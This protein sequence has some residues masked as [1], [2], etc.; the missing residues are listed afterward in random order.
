MARI[1]RLKR[2]TLSISGKLIERLPVVTNGLVAHFPFDGKGGMVDV[3]NGVTPVQAAAS[4]VNI[5]DCLMNSWR[6]PASWNVACVWDEAEQAIKFSIPSTI[7]VLSTYIPVDTSKHW[8]VEAAIK[9]A[10]GANGILYLG[11]ISY[12]ANKTQLP[13][14]P[15]TYDY[16]AAQGDTTVT[17][18][19]YTTFNNKLIG[20][21]NGTGKT[22]EDANTGNYTAFHPGTKF[23]RIMILTNYT[24]TVG[25]CFVK[26]L[27]LYHKD[28][29]TSNIVVHGS[30]ISLNEPV[31]NVSVMDGQNG[32]SPW[33]GDGSPSISIVDP[34]IEFRG[35]R[36]VRF[37]TGTAGNCY[38]TGST[39]IGTSISSVEW[40]NSLYIRRLDGSSIT[41]TGGYLYITNNTNVNGSVIIEE[42]EDKWYRIRYTRVGLVSGYPTLAG[43]Y[44]LGASTEYLFADWQIEPKPYASGYKAGAK[45]SSNL[46]LNVSA[47]GP[48]TL[49][50]DFI[51]ISPNNYA[52]Y[53]NWIFTHSPYN[54][55][56]IMW[57]RTAEDYYR[58]R[59]NAVDFTFLNTD[60]TNNNRY[61]VTLVMDTVK[62][63][64]FL[65]GVYKGEI[66]QVVDIT[67]LR[68]GSDEA[69]P[70]GNSKFYG[71]TIYNRALSSDEVMKLYH[72]SFQLK[73]NGNL[74]TRK[75]VEKPLSIPA[76]VVHFPLTCDLKDSYKNNNTVMWKSLV[77]V[78]VTD[79]TIKKTSATPA[80]DAGCVATE[81]VYGD[82]ILSF[83]CGQL[84]QDKMIG[85]SNIA[86]S[87]AVYSD[88]DHAIY[89]MANNKIQIYE[90][91]G[92]RGD[93]GSYA[94]NDIFTVNCENSVVKYYQ[95]GI[96]LYTSALAPT[97]PLTI[98][99]S[100]HTVGGLISDI[101][102]Y[103]R[104]PSC[105]FKEG[106][107]WVGKATTNL[108]RHANSPTDFNVIGNGIV[109]PTKFSDDHYEYEYR[110][111]QNLTWTYH[112]QSF[113]IVVGQVYMVSVD[114]FIS[115][116]T[117][118]PSTG[119]QFVA[120]CEGGLGISFYYDNTKK[121]QWQRLRSYAT[122]S[123]TASNFLMYP[124]TDG[125]PA[126]TG[127]V[128]Y[129]NIQV[130]RKNNYHTP[131]VNGIRAI[132]KPTFP[133]SLISL[134]EGTIA[135]WFK[136]TAAFFD[137]TLTSWNR[138]FG[139]STSANYNEIEV[140]R[141]ETTN[142]LSFMISNAAGAPQTSWYSCTS[143]TLAVDQWHHVVARWSIS[144]GTMSLTVNGVKIQQAWTVTYQP[145]VLG[146]F[147]L[148]W[149]SFIDRHS[150]AYFK[151]LIIAKYSMTDA[152]VTA[153]YRGE[154]KSNLNTL[155][156]QTQLQEGVI[157]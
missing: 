41:S 93:F 139:I 65:N 144:A 3:V 62:T 21:I 11:T 91:G 68:L 81:E 54:N 20:G 40:T 111:E 148:G 74:I 5:L 60:I 103:T 44:G 131:F 16:F 136:P 24:G 120:N 43:F 36:V 90:Q 66:P 73:S 106:A 142:T 147:D 18:I 88:I 156:I 95:N 61:L 150:E 97:F 153:M 23:V 6:D 63:M 58:I 76:N 126:T 102:L 35:H 89:L 154:M 125:S 9:N 45:L 19:S 138:V 67:G 141:Q 27:K 123:T 47:T 55:N 146:T 34:S 77:G 46:A 13:G 51:P 12:D 100:I 104:N 127:L 155:Q 130:E 15:G 132:A 135:V 69:G 115:S 38:L 56:L 124:C 134:S 129:K 22:G 112:G 119:T 137:N 8:Y 10:L 80:W 48:K 157:L 79:T 143:G 42:V 151:D 121:G 78:I 86:N 133:N 117:N 118:N 96:V 70:S 52:S 31:T 98:D 7:A 57:K 2:G 75:L 113:N 140:A 30:E 85:L 105:S 114:V 71:L 33:S 108:F 72:G 145:T 53:V 152:E 107:L 122:A 128:R 149:H 64:I 59:V 37:K 26:D 110:Y 1:G 83:K 50:F 87:D 82:C 109:T 28:T 14:H 84:A 32:V 4:E 101:S 92:H 25:G 99:C 29:D 49:S 116:D 17:N 94:I 39:Y